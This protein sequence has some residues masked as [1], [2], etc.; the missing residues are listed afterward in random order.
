MDFSKKIGKVI[1]HRSIVNSSFSYS[2]QSL[3][4]FYIGMYGRPENFSLSLENIHNNNREDVN[5]NQSSTLVAV[6]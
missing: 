4:Y 5:L 3:H 2:V 6:I 1:Q